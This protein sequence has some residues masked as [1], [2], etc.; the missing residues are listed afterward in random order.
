MP[1]HLRSRLG[2]VLVIAAVWL[3]ALALPVAAAGAVRYVDDNTGPNACHHTHFHTIQAAI[4]A[5]SAKDVVYVCKGTYDEELYIDV[6]G[7]TVQ[8]LEY[9]KAKLVPPS[10][11]AN[12]GQIAMVVLAADGVKFRGFKIEIPAGDVLPNIR[13]TGARAAGPAPPP[14]IGFEVVIAALGQRDGVWGNH[15]STI[16]DATLSGECGYGIGILFEGPLAAHV[17]F[18]KLGKQHSSA[19]RNYVRDFKL[20]GILAEGA[21]SVRIARNQIRYVHQNDPFTC[22]PINTIT[23]NPS[24]TFPCEEPGF[25]D[26]APLNGAFE[27]SVGIGVFGAKA[28]INNNSVFSTLDY[29]ILFGSAL[30]LAGGIITNA[31]APGSRITENQVNSVFLGIGVDPEG[32]IIIPPPVRPTGLPASGSMDVT[33]NRVSESFASIV[34]DSSDNYI[35]ANRSRLHIIGIG[36]DVGEN[37]TF[38]Q[39]DARYGLEFLAGFGYDCFDFTIG[40]GTEGTANTWTESFGTYNQPQDICEDVGPF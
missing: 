5:S 31:A 35:Y 21:L 27:E 6:P 20:A 22:V 29:A 37:N 33:F 17:N 10:S 9:R 12:D 13:T 19:K 1:G 25:L 26:M 32:I 16:G 39:N 8:S 18:T 30:P 24:L 2:A 28:D 23:V 40:T 36:T 14:C 3:G 11:T 38:L 7:L 15:I 4:N 34:V